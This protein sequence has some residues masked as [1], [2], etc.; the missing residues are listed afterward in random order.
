MAG[1]LKCDFYCSVS[2]PCSVVDVSVVCDCVITWSYLPTCCNCYVIMI[3]V[4]VMY[5]AQSLGQLPMAGHL[6][7][8]NI[9]VI[10]VLTLCQKDM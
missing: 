3:S 4:F 5:L 1:C 10:E 9:I 7:Y 6:I 8:F 2:L